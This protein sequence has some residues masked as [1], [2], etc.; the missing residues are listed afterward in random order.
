MISITL[1]IVALGAGADPGVSGGSASVVPNAPVSVESPI[2]G[3]DAGGAAQG[4]VEE[5][6]AKTEPAVAAAPAVVS[7]RELLPLG[8]PDSAVRTGRRD[9]EADAGAASTTG[10]GVWQTILC[11]GV[12]ILVILASRW[13]IVRTVRSPIGSSSLRSQLGVGGRAP[14]GL[15]FVLG[16]YPVSRGASL[17]LIQLDRR[18]LLLS[19]SGAGF[20]TLAEPRDAGEV[21]SIIAKARDEEGESLSAKFSTL[22]RTF[23]KKHV[24]SERAES[25]RSVVRPVRVVADGDEV[26]FSAG[27]VGD[28]SADAVRE[29]LTALGA[30]V[31]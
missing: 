5:P 11:T 9:G 18:V 26:S 20:Q 1:L 16:R 31:S 6:V 24:E 13:F 12:V 28:E 4:E 25:L 17:V 22:M 10:L 14:S 29:R 21:A 2:V 15:L 30:L 8:A 27:A 7:E 23:D 19:Q 3:L